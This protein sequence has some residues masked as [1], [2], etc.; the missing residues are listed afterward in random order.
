MLRLLV[1]IYL[2]NPRPISSAYMFRVI[3]FYAKFV[4]YYKFRNTDIPELYT[5]IP[6]FRGLY[7]KSSES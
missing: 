7:K 3:I 6:D 4:K 5:K 2:E 1:N